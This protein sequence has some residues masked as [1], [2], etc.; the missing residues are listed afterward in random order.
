MI[1]WTFT[2]SC[3]RKGLDN[4]IDNTAPKNK[5]RGDNCLFIHSR[6]ATRAGRSQCHGKPNA[7]TVKHTAVFAVYRAWKWQSGTR[8]DGNRKSH[9]IIQRHPCLEGGV[10]TNFL[11]GSLSFWMYVSRINL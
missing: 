2:F 7:T 10:L 5:K 6:T 8:V 3:D 11:K 4:C 9:D 1:V